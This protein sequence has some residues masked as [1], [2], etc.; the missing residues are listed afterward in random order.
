VALGGSLPSGVPTDIYATLAD[1]AA[2]HG[3][4][5]VLDADGEP[6]VHGVEG[7]ALPH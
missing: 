7:F 6:L 4:K 3:A 1:I 2:R 5:V